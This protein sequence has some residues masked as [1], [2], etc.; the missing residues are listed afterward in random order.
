M[1]YIFMDES[2]DLGFD[3]HKDKTSNFFIITF[4]FIEDVRSAEKILKKV[5]GSM[6]KI[7]I[8]SLSGVLHAYKIRPETRLKALKLISQKDIKIMTIILNKQKVFAR[9]QNEKQILYNYITNILID[10][11]ISKKIVPINE[12]ITLI[13]SRRET[14]KFL[15]ENFCAYLQSQ[16]INDHQVQVDVSIQTATQAKCLQLADLASWS[17]FRKHEHQ[18]ALYYD[19]IKRNI[20]EENDLFR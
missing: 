2:G 7:E 8:K 18:D 6:T 16:S 3:L 19:I 14:N 5:F 1:S 17:I 11:I 9:L 12:R 15:N 4:L 13:A 10:R 20:L